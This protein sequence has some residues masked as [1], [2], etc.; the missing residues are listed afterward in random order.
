MTSL[1]RP[2]LA[3]PAFDRRRLRI[4]GFVPQPR[5]IASVPLPSRVTTNIGLLGPHGAFVLVMGLE[6]G[7]LVAVRQ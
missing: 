5:D 2:H 3:V 6:D 1:S 7:R 4:V